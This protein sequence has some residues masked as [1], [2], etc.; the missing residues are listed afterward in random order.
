M[1]KKKRLVEL[2]HSAGEFKFILLAEIENGDEEDYTIV[3][4]LELH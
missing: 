2:L 1:K 3:L 4:E